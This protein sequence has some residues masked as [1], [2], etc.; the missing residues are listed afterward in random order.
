MPGGMI[1]FLALCGTG[2]TVF[3]FGA[4][5]PA[6]VVSACC[7]EADLSTDLLPCAFLMGCFV[8]FCLRLPTSI[9]S[10]AVGTAEVLARWHGSRFPLSL[11]PSELLLHCSHL[12]L[13]C[14]LWHQHFP[15]T[16]VAVCCNPADVLHEP[17]ITGAMFSP[18]LWSLPSF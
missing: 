8:L 16:A 6:R 1:R 10:S 5:V 3:A 7:K 18:P 4:A 9:F 17:Q 12:V 2:L 14:F 13:F 15:A 11:S